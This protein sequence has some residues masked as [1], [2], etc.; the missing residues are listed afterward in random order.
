MEVNMKKWVL[1]AI[2]AMMGMNAF[3]ATVLSAYIDQAKKE[4][5]VEIRHSGGCGFHDFSLEIFDCQET[6]PV[7][8]KAKLVDSTTDP[9]EALL[10]SFAHISLE[11]AGLTDSYFKGGTLKILGD[12][13]VSHGKTSSATVQLPN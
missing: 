6:Y 2:S 12:F 8:C 1:V 7:S 11:E 10:H 3:G 9:C 5:V 13:D 4:L